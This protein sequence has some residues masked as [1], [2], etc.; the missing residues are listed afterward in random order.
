MSET[1]LLSERDKGVAI[2]TLNRTRAKNA[3][4]PGL[5]DALIV[6]LTH[7]RED[8]S[9]RA[10]VLTGAGVDFC[11]GGDVRGMNQG[12]HS[13][14]QLRARM[15]SYHPLLLALQQLD[16]PLIAAVDGVAFGAGFSL[17]LWADI[18]LASDRAR[19]SM[20]F[21]RIGLVP[22]LGALYMLPRVLGLQRA[23]EL[24]F[25][26]RE[27]G[28]DE[29]QR[30]GLVLEVHP[31][32]ALLP[33]ALQM[34]AS[35]TG[36]SSLALSLSKRA[37]QASLQSDLPTMLELEADAQALARGSEYHVEAVRRFA[38]KEAPQFQW[39]AASTD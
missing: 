26:G 38:A 28:A 36:A 37:L 10:V 6:Q 18:V 16:K 14:Q 30:I 4:D 20:V 1:P 31:A 34:A 35:F 8:D 24:T 15:Q 19:F 7:A 17:A 13:H 32:D 39:Q 11:S 2:L 27:L 22:D 25:S 33:R 5:R 29:A 12:A 9:V 3:L 23:R 21:Q